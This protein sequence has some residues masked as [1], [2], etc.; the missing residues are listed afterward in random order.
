MYK[1]TSTA[2]THFLVCYTVQYP[3][4]GGG[5]YK[6]RNFYMSFLIEKNPWKMELGFFLIALAY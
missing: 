5:N 6:P 1:Y 4:N 3:T 2:R